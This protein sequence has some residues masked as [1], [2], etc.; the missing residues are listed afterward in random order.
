[1]ATKTR[2]HTESSALAERIISDPAI[3]GGTPVVKG[4]HIP[5]ERLLAQLSGKPDV[6]DVLALYP[7]LTKEDIQAVFA[8]ARAAVQA[9]VRSGQ[10]IPPPAPDDIWAN[11]DPD[12]ALMALD[13]L[14]EALRGVDLD[15]LRAD[16]REAR[17]HTTDELSD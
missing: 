9:Q 10:P 11:Y 3:H 6:A 4:T 14:A 12:R 2:A 17:G 16:I 15:R 5:V 7:E 1:M 8:Y 13:R